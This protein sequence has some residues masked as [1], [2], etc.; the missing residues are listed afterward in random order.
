MDTPIDEKLPAF[1]QLQ[2]QSVKAE[3]LDT[4][5]RCI[6][7]TQRRVS[8]D[9]KRELAQATRIVSYALV[10]DA[11]AVESVHHP[12]ISGDVLAPKRPFEQESGAQIVSWPIKTREMSV[13]G[14]PQRQGT[15]VD[16]RKGGERQR[17]HD[18]IEHRRFT[19]AVGVDLEKVSAIGKRRHRS[20]V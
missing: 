13:D 9:Q 7:E 14:L 3:L 11:T 18:I 19:N 2:R 1:G 17:E 16:H 5:I 10:V 8:S 4:L 6:G 12:P 20:N 15:P